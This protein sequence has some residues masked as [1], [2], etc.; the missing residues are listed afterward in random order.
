MKSN[1]GSVDR[2]LRIVLGVIL[3]ALIFV[4]EGGTRW[5][6][7]LGLVLIGTAFMGFCP[8]YGLL[9]VRTRRN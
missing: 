2:V 5:I 1:I 9:G 3:L 6:G 7:L 4:L 8:A